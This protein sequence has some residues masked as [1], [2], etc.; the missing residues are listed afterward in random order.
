[1]IRAV[2]SAPTQ[3]YLD[4]MGIRRDSVI[5]IR[6][7]TYMLARIE[8]AIGRPLLEAT[9][10]ELRIWLAQRSG[11]ITDATLRGELSALRAFFRW[12]QDMDLRADNPATRLPMPRAPR[13]VPRPMAEDDFAF[14]LRATVDPAMRA[15]LALAGMAGLRAIEIARLDW[16]EVDTERQTLT[17]LR[18]K[19]NHARMVPVPA[20]LLEVLA[21]IPGPRRGPVIRRN[22]DDERHLEHWGVSHRAN[23]HLHR[24]GITSTLHTLRHRAAT[25]AYRATRDPFAVRD[26]LGHTSTQ[27]TALYAAPNS[28]AIRACAD[29]VGQMDVTR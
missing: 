23:D 20:A 1:M 21:A 28:E 7:R 22:E 11:S 5:T 14:A 19:G 24:L 25:I 27:T 3:R 4:F 15:I 9:L 12:A 16:S 10:D 29:A 18:G 26:F 17:V 2:V 6:S 13:R 8:A